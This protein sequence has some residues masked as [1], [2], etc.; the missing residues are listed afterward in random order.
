[1]KI[2]S[3]EDEKRKLEE[4]FEKLKDI[5]EE[6]LYQ[7]KDSYIESQIKTKET[8]MKLDN[9]IKNFNLAYIK[10]EDHIQEVISINKVKFRYMLLN[11][12]W[13]E[14]FEYVKNECSKRI[15]NLTNII[16]KPEMQLIF[17]KL[18]NYFEFNKKIDTES[19]CLTE[20]EFLIHKAKLETLSNQGNII[21]EFNAVEINMEDLKI[22]NE[23]TKF[24]KL[25]NLRKK[26]NQ[27]FNVKN[28][29]K[30]RY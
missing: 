1:M 27:K 11:K 14:K 21:N 7:I 9:E 13:Q 16:H 8:I 15:L 29:V 12:T 3:I 28:D 10:K 2:K 24:D 30:C 23:M 20:K 4:N 18:S 26:V 6:K 22:R 5:Y 17:K 25:E 19:L